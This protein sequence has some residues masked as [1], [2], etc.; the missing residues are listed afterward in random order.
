[1]AL[2]TSKPA[3]A[4]AIAAAFSMFAVPA[5]AA[6]LPRGSVPAIY[7]SRSGDAQGY[8]R[9][10]GYGHGRHHHDDD[11]DAGDILTG[12]LILGGIAAI[13]T[14]AGK[15]QQEPYRYPE[16]ANYRRPEAQPSLESRGLDR[17]ADMCVA[18]VERGGDARVDSVDSVG[19]TGEGWHVGGG[20]AGGEA[21][22]CWIDND[23]HVS[24]V[25]LGGYGANAG[26]AGDHVAGDGQWSDE[27]YARARAAQDAGSIGG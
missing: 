5:A 15:G 23:G 12:V 3:A 27:D 4:I 10:Y 11:I 17:A 24:D 13:A 14:A 16:D 7:D 2:T 18:E 9:G 26:D 21:W 20:L 6:E 19:R 8:G 22:D 25:R 1:M